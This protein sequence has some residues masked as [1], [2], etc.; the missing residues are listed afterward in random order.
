MPT[1]SASDYTTFLKFKAAAATPIR[2]DI[3]TRTNA[4]LNQSVLNANILASQAALVVTPTITV[5]QGNA[6]VEKQQVVQTRANPNALSTI[7]GSG[8]MSSSAIQRPGGLPIGFR[9]SQ[10]TYTRL[11][12]NAG[13][14][15]GRMLSSGQKLF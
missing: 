12:Q 1:L 6:R 3:Q 13:W 4:T 10:N 5:V 14:I 15:Q 11:P 2:P 7:A 8:A 9:G